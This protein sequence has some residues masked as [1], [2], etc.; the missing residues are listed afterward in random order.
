MIRAGTLFAG[1]LAIALLL[2][3]AP[4]RAEVDEAARG[5]VETEPVPEELEEAQPAPEEPP[6]P[7]QPAWEETACRGALAALH[8]DLEAQAAQHG[9]VDWCREL[10]SVSSG[11]WQARAY[12]DGEAFRSEELRTARPPQKLTGGAG[13]QGSPAQVGAVATTQGVPTVGGNVGLI[14]TET[15]G[16]MLTTISFNPV[17]LAGAGSSKEDEF[18]RAGDISLLLPIDP[19]S[20]GQLMDTLDYLGIRARINL[21][22][23]PAI[24]TF[25][26]SRTAADEEFAKEI[27]AVQSGDALRDDVEALL[28]RLGEARGDP[29]DLLPCADAVAAG[30]EAGAADACGEALPEL[31]RVGAAEA[32]LRT[33]LEQAR[34]AVDQAYVGGHINVDIGDPTFSKLEE[35]RGFWLDAA[36]A[37]GGRGTVG[38]GGGPVELGGHGSVAFAFTR[39]GEASQFG[40]EAAGGVELGFTNGLQGAYL[41]AGVVGQLHFADRALVEDGPDP[42]RLDIRI[43]MAVPVVDGARI[44]VSLDIPLAK[45]A[46]EPTLTVSADWAAIF[47]ALQPNEP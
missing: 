34:R 18:S 12:R 41:K 6:P 15:G 40:L 32:R 20:S 11:I 10:A 39:I 33:Q 46:R 4:V 24:Q 38:G 28:R 36:F 31:S 43:G 5:P 23:R 17:A 44:N 13:T 30:D 26:S 2:A 3:P 14:G 21:H 47:G 45:E 9:A 25:E 19:T 7:L 35:N 37:G 1:V 8:P 42:S 29:S 22:A 16:R 27:E